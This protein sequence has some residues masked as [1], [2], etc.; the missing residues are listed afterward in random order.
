[1]SKLEEKLATYGA[2][3]TKMGHKVDA[4]LLK[5]VT[6]AC[7]PSIYNKDSETVASSSETELNT[8]RTNFIGKKLGITDAAKVDAAVAKVVADFGSA[9]KNKYRA[10]FYYLLAVHFKKEAQ[11]KK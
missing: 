10:V 8:V 3:L 6:K 4:N 5:G 1:M 7:G 11:F 2:A 9:N